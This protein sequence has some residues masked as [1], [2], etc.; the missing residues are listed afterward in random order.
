MRHE[1]LIVLHGCVIGGYVYLR[2]LLSHSG[3]A[4]V[5]QVH[6]VVS[7]EDNSATFQDLLVPGLPVV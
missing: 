4:S 2:L 6:F 7:L 1:T 3:K 5:E